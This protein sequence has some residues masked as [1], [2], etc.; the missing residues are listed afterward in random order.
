[1]EKRLKDEASVFDMNSADGEG[2][3]ERRPPDTP[4]FNKAHSFKTAFYDNPHLMT[5]SDVATGRLLAVNDAFTRQT[6]YSREELLGISSVALGIII[7][8]DRDRLTQSMRQE[9]RLRGIEVVLHKKDGGAFWVKYY[10]DVLSIDGIT[11]LLSTAHDITAQKA[12][13]DALRDEKEK[14]ERIAATVPGVICA[15]KMGPDGTVRFP[16]ASLATMDVFGYAPERLAEDASPILQRV[17]VD[18]QAAVETSVQASAAALTPW[19]SEFRYNHPAKGERWLEGRSMPVHEADG[20]T[21]WHGFVTDIT[22]RKQFDEALRNVQRL[23]SL[24][25]LAGGIAHDFNNLLGGIFGYIDLALSV[26][27]D[28]KVIEYLESSITAMNRMRALTLQLLT[29][30]KGGAPIRKV[31]SLV[32][33][34]QDTV[35]FALSGSSIA[36]RCDVP[37]TLQL[38]EIDEHQIGQVF[39]NIII[40]A[41][42]A[43]PNGGTI[44]VSA[45]NRCI[46]KGDH[47]L[48]APGDYVKISIRDFGIGMPENILTHIFDPFYTTK[49][50]GH[51]L[52]LATCH[53]IVKRHGGAIDVESKSGEGTTFYIHLPAARSSETSKTVDSVE[54]RQRIGGTVVV[55]DDDETLIHIFR[56]MLTA[57]GYTA[58]CKTNGEQVLD[59]FQAD[60]GRKSEIAAM[61]FDLTIP[62]GMGGVET[63]AHIRSMNKDIPIFVVSGYSEDPVMVNPSAYGF[64]A[65][66]AKPFTLADLSRTLH[67]HSKK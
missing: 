38:C 9:G 8:K 66:I 13:E 48:L 62:G 33:F 32:P 42:Q 45:R 61:I 11:V 54:S 17:H 56:Q 16:Y 34:L 19:Q 24:G 60:A 28:L 3:R 29:F 49:A 57:L 50:S 30:S 65:S 63:V 4:E 35:Q 51:G 15:L 14:L 64:S 58:V 25:V 67:H 39:D 43:M 37:H 10:G 40:N 20:A 31:A 7:Q 2:M 22:A 1:M 53:S 21:V 27:T 47:P 36:L 55:M 18:D 52:G 41:K 59:Y 44:E 6:G 12:A 5:I 23:E 46:Q 26:A